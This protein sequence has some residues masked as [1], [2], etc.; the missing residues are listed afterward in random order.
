LLF[1]ALFWVLNFALL[2][3]CS[4]A[5]W[6]FALVLS[7]P[8]IF[9]ACTFVLLDF[10]A[11]NF[12]HVC[13][14]LHTVRKG[15]L[16][17]DRQNRT[18]KIGQLEYDSQNGIGRIRLP[19][20]DFK[21]KQPG[22]DRPGRNRT[23]RTGQAKQDHQNGTTRQNRTGKKDTQKRTG[24]AARTGVSQNGKGRARLQADRT[25]RS[26]LPAQHCQDS[27]TR[28]GHL[29]YSMTVRTG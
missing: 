10:L 5:P 19:W 25:D 17:Q 21:D 29:E 4:H 28:T 23:G 6:F 24:K 18:A 12:A 1:C 7:R 16:W 2:H 13:L 8:L 27:T 20:Q 15:Q 3:L 11:L 26:G 22:Q 14:F 9:C